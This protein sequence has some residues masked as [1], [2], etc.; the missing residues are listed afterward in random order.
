MNESINFEN[1]RDWGSNPSSEQRMNPFTRAGIYSYL[2]VY[3]RKLTY[4]KGGR[5]TDRLFYLFRFDQTS[6]SVDNVYVT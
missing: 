6:K 3:E 2:I 4:F 1:K 5:F